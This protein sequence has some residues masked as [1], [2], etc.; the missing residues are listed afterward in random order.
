M[1]ESL[2]QTYR[3][4]ALSH[5]R[6]LSLEI[7]DLLYYPK[8]AINV[9]IIIVGDPGHGKSVAAIALAEGVSFWNSLREHGDL[10]HM[11]DYFDMNDDHVGIMKKNDIRK[12]FQNANKIHNIYIG[13]DVGAAWNSRLWGKLFNQILNAYVGTDR[14]FRTCKIITLAS[15]KELDG[16]ARNKFT[17]YIEMDGPQIFEHNLTFGKLFRIKGKPR[18]GKIF[19]PGY[20]G[21]DQETGERIKYTKIAFLTPSSAMFKKYNSLRD[22]KAREFHV[23]QFKDLDEWEQILKNQRNGE[24][25]H[26]RGGIK[27]DALDY[28]KEHPAPTDDKTKY[29]QQVASAVGAKSAESIRKLAAGKW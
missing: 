21:R 29:Y 23:E 28:M 16:Q 3:K 1:S 25:D 7:S 14:T 13:D 6:C 19:Y 22:S 17:H 11:T 5:G 15:D 20:R 8:A 2:Y 24:N 9:K 18:I 10:D 27:Q 12:T 26:G 4:L